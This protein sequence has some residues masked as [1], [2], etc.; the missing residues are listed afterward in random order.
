MEGNPFHVEE[1]TFA[2][3]EEVLTT[4]FKHVRMFAQDNWITSAVLAPSTME[5]ADN[6]ITGGVKVYKTVGK[7]ATETLYM[8]SLCS[9]L[10]LPKAA[11]EVALTDLHEMRHYAEKE[12]ELRDKDQHI[13]NIE[14]AL[15]TASQEERFAKYKDLQDQIAEL[16]PSL[17]LYDQLE[18]HAV[19]DYV[20]WAPEANSAVMGHQIYAPRIGVSP[21]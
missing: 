21:P 20:E 17:F 8:V 11:Q 2:E 15:A 5:R 19:A 7:P 4:R 10:P 3:L 9:D 13:A 16:A 6:P 1:F 14:D 12:R 18:K